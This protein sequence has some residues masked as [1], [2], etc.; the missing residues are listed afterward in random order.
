M[1]NT[2]FLIKAWLSTFSV[3]FLSIKHEYSKRQVRVFCTPS[4]TFLFTYKNIFSTE[5]DITD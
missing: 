3:S 2:A 5:S 4:K 1:S